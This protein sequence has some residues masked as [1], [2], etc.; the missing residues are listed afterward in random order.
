MITGIKEHS[1]TSLAE[2]YKK[3]WSLGLAGIDITI[4]IKW[5]GL[6]PN[7][8]IKTDNGYNYMDKRKEH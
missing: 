6:D 4:N 1:I 5:D 3:I 8:L 2:M 7:I